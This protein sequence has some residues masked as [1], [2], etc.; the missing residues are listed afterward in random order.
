MSEQVKAGA[1]SALIACSLSLPTGCSFNTSTP[2]P[3]CTESLRFY[4]LVRGRGVLQQL[5]AGQ[6]T[7]SASR[8]STDHAKLLRIK[9]NSGV[10]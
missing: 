1:E 7:A 8:H 4:A 5:H 10:G 2:T 6:S 9:K 3:D